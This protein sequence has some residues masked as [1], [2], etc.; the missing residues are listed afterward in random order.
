MT[1]TSVL[2]LGVILVLIGILG[3]VSNPLIGTDSIFSTNGATNWLHIAAGI[4]IFIYW[5]YGE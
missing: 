1:K 3:F 4:A 5:M 2:I